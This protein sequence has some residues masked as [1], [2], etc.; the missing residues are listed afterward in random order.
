MN[1]RTDRR[2]FLKRCAATS[3]AAVGGLGD[4]GTLA[5][6]RPA[7]AS[8]TGSALVKMHFDPDTDR[9]AQL[10]QRTSR[11]QI[12]PVMVEQLRK[13]LS[14]RK[15]LAALFRTAQRYHR[16]EHQILVAHS[17]HQLSLDAGRKEQLLPLFYHL[18]ALKKADYANAVNPEIDSLK[19][20]LPAP[21]KAAALF[22]EAIWKKD[23]ETANRAII[24]M[25]RSEG[26]QAAFQQVWRNGSTSNISHAHTIIAVSNMYRTLQVIG[27]QDAEPALRKLANKCSGRVTVW[28]R[29]NADRA[30]QAAVKVPA[31]WT[32]R[33]SDKGAVLELIAMF[34]EGKA[35]I[36]CQSTCQQLL[37]GKLHAGAVWDAIFLTTNE[38][39]VRQN[40]EGMQGTARHSFTA[41]NAMH[42]AFRTQTEPEVRLF[43]LL[44]AVA[45][46]C[47]F[48]ALSIDRDDLND[49]NITEISE[50]VSPDSVEDAVDEIFALLPPWRPEHSFRDRSGQDEAL[51]LT[52]AM[53]RKHSD[54]RFLQTSRRMICLKSTINVHNV[55]FPVAAFENYQY[56]SPEWRPNFL[57]GSIFLLNGT[58][59]EDNTAVQEAREALRSL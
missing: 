7:S 41:T 21:G 3:T 54:Q 55:K 32:S 44:Q 15:F 1:N 25:C 20:P 23:P 59:M 13:G 42:F 57:A 5:Q 37:A 22:D 26:P 48:L 6:T 43:T 29:A 28:D 27:W 4:V 14:H 33:R 10:I 34:R 31:D 56:V 51:K 19:G 53:A 12:I 24:S 16:A 9:L 2:G 39:S 52:Y 46:T 36:A 38:Y 35:G 30:R 58:Q 8:Q 45:M 40:A 17:V 11:D 49:F 47:N 18:D 50:I